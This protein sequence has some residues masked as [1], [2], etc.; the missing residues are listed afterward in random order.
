MYRLQDFHPH[1]SS[2]PFPPGGRDF[3]AAL[4]RRAIIDRPYG[5]GRTWCG[6][7]DTVAVSAGR[8]AERSMP[9]PYIG[10][11]VCKGRRPRRPARPAGAGF[12]KIGDFRWAVREA[13]PYDY[14]LVQHV[15][16]GPLDDPLGA[17]A[18]LPKTSKLRRT[19]PPGRR[20]RRPLQNTRKYPPVP[21]N[22]GIAFGTELR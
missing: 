6:F 13:G 2:A 20:G 17:V 3:S 16:V 7:A 19:L 11:P 1:S 12:P 15:G 4:R 18:N 22:R 14:I 5:V 9:V 8:T 21:R 10:Y